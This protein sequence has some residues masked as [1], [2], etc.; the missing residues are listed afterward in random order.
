MEQREVE[1]TIGIRKKRKVH[2]RLPAPAGPG[3]DNDSPIVKKRKRYKPL[4][5]EED[6][7]GEASDPALTDEGRKQHRPKVKGRGKGKVPSRITDIF[8]VIPGTEQDNDPEKRELDPRAFEG[9]ISPRDIGSS[10]LS[11]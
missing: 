5:V 1:E 3:R 7:E 2:P 11:F 9:S 10:W 4:P 6:D 8:D